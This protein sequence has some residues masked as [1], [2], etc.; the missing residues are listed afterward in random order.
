VY[1]ASIGKQYNTVSSLL[2]AGTSVSTASASPS[3]VPA[4]T[5]VSSS[6]SSPTVGLL[7]AAAARSGHSFTC[8]NQL[9]RGFVT[10]APANATYGVVRLAAKVTLQLCSATC[11]LQFNGDINRR[12]PIGGLT[13]AFGRSF[14]TFGGSV[15][16]H[17]AQRSHRQSP[18]F[19]VLIT[20]LLLDFLRFPFLAALRF[21]AFLR[22]LR[23]L[24]R[25]GR[26]FHCR[27]TAGFT[28]SFWHYGCRRRFGS[29]RWFRLRGIFGP[30]VIISHRFRGFNNGRACRLCWLRHSLFWDDR[31]FVCSS[32]RSFDRDSILRLQF[33]KISFAEVV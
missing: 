20:V 23:L 22:G 30:S 7:A 31:S 12:R 9:K 4:V 15:A 21:R 10:T 26:R 18:V 17:V 14:P 19:L 6:S 29:N 25:D 16:R 8:G 13:G 2:V 27:F 33:G 3:I 5:L 11:S 32:K 1:G 28:D 24:L